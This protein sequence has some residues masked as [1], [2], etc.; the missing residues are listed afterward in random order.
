[1]NAITYD[2]HRPQSRGEELANSIS[3]GMGL[4]LAIASLPILLVQF[5]DKGGLANIVA[6]CVYSTT[7][8]MLYLV[9]TLYHAFPEGTTKTRM[10]R[11]DHASIYIFIAGS[12]TPFALGAMRGNWGWTVF[13]VIWAMAIFGFTAKLFNRFKHPWLSTGLYIAMGWS[14]LFAAGPLMANMSNMGLAWL[15]AG[16]LFYT[17]GAIVFLFDHRVKYAHFVWHLFVLGGTLCHFF[18]VLWHSQGLKAI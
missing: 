1:M 11:L 7:M 9:S 15:V 14:V 3:H 16:G 8:M 2:R 4:L 17:L 18:A 12:Y 6:A 5:S 10:N 13:G